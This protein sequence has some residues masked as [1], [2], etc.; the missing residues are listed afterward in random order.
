MSPDLFCFSRSCM[1]RSCK[2]VGCASLH[3][4]FLALLFC[5]TC[6]CERAHLSRFCLFCI[7][8]HAHFSNAAMDAWPRDDAR[9]QRL[10][11]HQCPSMPTTTT[12]TTTTTLATDPQRCFR[13]QMN[14]LLGPRG[15]A[16]DLRGNILGDHHR[17]H[18]HHH[19]HL[20][21]LTRPMQPVSFRNARACRGTCLCAVLRVS[22]CMLLVSWLSCSAGII[23]MRL[24][25]F[26]FVLLWLMGLL[27]APR[28]IGDSCMRHLA[29]S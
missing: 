14:V 19:H 6:V 8:A 29:L 7:R 13:F 12:T 22:S 15:T 24:L 23:T 4:A 9:R 20:M 2:S 5:T 10:V 26:C 11:R 1:F 27:H 3:I 17:H 21:H 16:R 28:V 18:H 25:V